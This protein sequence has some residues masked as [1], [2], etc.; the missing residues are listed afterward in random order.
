MKINI[1]YCFLSPG[2][3][4]WFGLVAIISQSSLVAF[5]TSEDLKVSIANFIING[6]I[7]LGCINK[8]VFNAKCVAL[9]WRLF[10]A[11]PTDEYLLMIGIAWL[12]DNILII[13]SELFSITWIGFR[14]SLFSK[15]LHNFPCTPTRKSKYSTTMLIIKCVSVYTVNS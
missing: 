15:T 2:W 6:W 11:D 8:M 9:C 5:M 13:F 12:L 3:Y 4:N 1:T 10:Q 14:F 7:L